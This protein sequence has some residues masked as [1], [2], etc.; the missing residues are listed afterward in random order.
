MSGRHRADPPPRTTGRRALVTGAVA[1]VAA[2][3]AAG[4]W[5]GLRGGDGGAAGVRAVADLSGSDSGSD[6][7]SAA[8]AS[9]ASSA[10]A[11]ASTSASAS[12]DP[13]TPLAWGPTVGEL[14]DARAL[15]A[16][17]S[18]SALAGQVIVGRFSS[19]DPDVPADLVRTLGLAGVCV[20]PESVSDS[21]Q[22][23]A[24]TAAV[25]AA[26]AESRP[27]VPAVIGADEEG[28]TVEHLRAVA[29]SFPSFATA[30][31]AITA[32]GSAGRR[33]V[34][35]AA[36]WTGLE[37][38]DLGF[39][40]VFA[41]VA[42]VTIGAAD[43]TIGTRSAS[44]DP[45][46]AATAVGQAVRGYLAA[47]IVSTAKHFPGHGSATVDSHEALPVITESLAELRERDL[48]PFEEAV[49]VG[50]PAVMVGHLDVPALAPGGL[51][52]SLSAAAYTYLRSTLGFAGVAITDSMGMG[53]VMA[54]PGRAVKA[55][56]AGADLLLMP[57]DT[58]GTH[59]SVRRALASGALERDRVEEAAARVVALQAW[60]A[61]VSA[62][63]AVPTDVT[64]RTQQAAADLSAAA[65]G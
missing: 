61:R 27:G 2:A 23:R 37:M 58:A 28:G 40:W 33:A 63:V 41:P 8:S 19:T 32:S 4:A 38:R 6:A 30:G 29:T 47:G 57:A 36:R 56:A 13:D 54:V 1:G 21:T 3:G 7:A 10:S 44:Q 43:V 62:Q 18:P 51:P 17:M 42:D 12:P 64:T 31:Q 65:W 39:T 5:V 16:E 9:S 11:S 46:V 48:V 14:E 22:V 26:V 35:E 34:R 25:T 52:T 49:A 50:S 60:Q 45:Q 59:D 15:V 55:L 20:T 53:A 24:L